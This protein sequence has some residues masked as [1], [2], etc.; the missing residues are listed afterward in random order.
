MENITAAIPELAQVEPCAVR[1]SVAPRH[2]TTRLP[3]EQYPA[4]EAIA[5]AGCGL[6]IACICG[7]ENFFD[8]LEGVILTGSCSAS[9]AQGKRNK[10]LVLACRCYRIR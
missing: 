3:F 10:Y 1:L 4:F 2:D 7:N 6:N 5:A 9:Q 8:T